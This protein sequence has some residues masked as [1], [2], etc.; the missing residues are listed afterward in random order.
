MQRA[1]PLSKPHSVMV[2]SRGQNSLAHP[3]PSARLVDVWCETVE[4]LGAHAA[5]LLGLSVV[6][7]AIA[8]LIGPALAVVAIPFTRA[9]MM[10]IVVRENKKLDRYDVR[11]PLRG[12]VVWQIC[13]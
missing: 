3:A 1:I 10:Q 13:I 4:Q 11:S 6:G 9:A 7:F 8:S 5:P 2:K 12:S